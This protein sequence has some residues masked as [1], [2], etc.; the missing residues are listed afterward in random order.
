M[1]DGNGVG[2]EQSDDKSD[3]AGAAVTVPFPQQSS[4]E[5]WAVQQ[6]RTPRES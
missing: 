5:C 2:C 4:F 6:G 1:V 3:T